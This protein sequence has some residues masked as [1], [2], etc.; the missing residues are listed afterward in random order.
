[1]YFDRDV[2]C[3]RVYFRK[4]F[5]FDSEEFPVF[6]TDT[7]RTIDLD[8][9]LKASGCSEKEQEDFDRFITDLN[10]HAKEADDDE[11]DDEGDDFAEDRVDTPKEE[12]GHSGDEG[13]EGDEGDNDE[14]EGDEEEGDEE[15]EDEGDEDE[16]NQKARRRRRK[17]NQTDIAVK[18]RV[19]KLVKSGRRWG[20]SKKA[21]SDAKRNTQKI[22]RNKEKKM[23]KAQLESVKY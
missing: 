19:D 13:D 7:E 23:I 12:T 4:R 15:E 14:E 10:D 22:F 18:R 1:M 2:E 17:R 3:V 11:G 5:K 20:K 21:G 9:T 8:T 6:G 16:G